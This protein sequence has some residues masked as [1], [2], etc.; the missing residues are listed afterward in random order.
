MPI[1]FA[2]LNEAWA[3]ALW[4]FVFA[5]ITDFLDGL[6]A[7]KL[8]AYSKIGEDLDA[9]SDASLVVSGVLAL[10]ITGH[11]PWW[12]TISV[13]V[14]GFGVG[15]ER[16][17]VHRPAW[18]M[19]FF[20]VIAVGGLFI[21]WTAIGWM[22]AAQAYGWSWLYVPLTLLVLAICA[23]LK[24]HRIYAWLHPKVLPPPPA[25]RSGRGA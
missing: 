11:L 4:L 15:L 3:L 18:L 14:I 6:A 20:K 7:R 16:L 24:P 8:G 22:F 13:L 10:S 23:A 5:L 17:L 19:I 9:Y 12:I 21:E 25:K 1:F 2:A